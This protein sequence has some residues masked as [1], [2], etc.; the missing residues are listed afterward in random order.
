[1]KKLG[2][3]KTSLTLIKNP[4]SLNQTKYIDVIHHHVCG[5]VDNRE[6]GIE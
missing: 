3:K 5:L 4:E 2:N 1:M 6:L